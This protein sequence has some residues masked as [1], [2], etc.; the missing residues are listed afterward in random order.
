[1]GT[2]EG[3]GLIQ[4]QTLARS[5]FSVQSS[6]VM[7]PIHEFGSEEQKT[8]YLPRLASGALVGCFGL[9]EPDA[10]SDPAGMKTT[11]V[12]Q[13]ADDTYRINGSKTW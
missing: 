6:L 11:A 10:G 1:M 13:K 5:M 4:Y 12:Y 8:H 3:K 2:L 7:L 9:T